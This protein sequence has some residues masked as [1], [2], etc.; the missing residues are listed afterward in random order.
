MMG[1][2]VFMIMWILHVATLGGALIITGEPQV[3]LVHWIWHF[4]YAVPIGLIGWM[5]R[6]DRAFLEGVALG[7][8]TYML[9]GMSMM[10]TLIGRDL[11]K[12]LT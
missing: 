10:A 12:W 7:S 6:K 1:S 9:L 3:L 4:A 2:R 8:A 5:S 11:W